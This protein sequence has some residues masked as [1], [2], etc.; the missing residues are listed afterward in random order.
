MAEKK[1]EQKV[2]QKDIR[3]QLEEIVDI[4]WANH[5]LCELT[6]LAKVVQHQYD[7]T[8]DVIGDKTGWVSCTF[9]E[10]VGKEIEAKLKELRTLLAL[11]GH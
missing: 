10:M 2:N 1:N 5:L 11:D 4:S 9:P 7:I 6:A 8:E 3:K